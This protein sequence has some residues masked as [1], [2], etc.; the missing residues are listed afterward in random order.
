MKTRSLY[1]PSPHSMLI[2]L[3]L[4]LTLILT[5]KSTFIPSVSAQ[6]FAHAEKKQQKQIEQSSSLYSIL[7][8]FQIISSGIYTL[9]SYTNTL[10]EYSYYSY[11]S[12][13]TLISA[14]PYVVDMTITAQKTLPKL[15][16]AQGEAI[17]VIVNAL[18]AW[19]FSKEEKSNSNIYSYS[20]SNSNGDMKK[21]GKERELELEGSPL[22]LAFTGPT[23]VGKTETAYQLSK[24]ILT[25][26]SYRQISS[27]FS[28]FSSS[29]SN[30]SGSRSGGGGGGGR[31]DEGTCL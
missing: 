4:I 3:L 2:S 9:S 21:G 14:C 26:T 10:L 15:I 20:Y 28:Y 11:S 31:G 1:R 5:L 13:P 16:K 23:G 24:S 12:S 29:S 18:A 8:P 27:I 22:V 25:S 17:R 6:V 19:E 7:N 30:K